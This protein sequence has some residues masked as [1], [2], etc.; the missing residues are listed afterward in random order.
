MST[1]KFDKYNDLISMLF[2]ARQPSDI[3]AYAFDDWE[4][5]YLLVDAPLGLQL[6]LNT[7]AVDTSGTNEYMQWKKVKNILKAFLTQDMSPQFSNVGWYDRIPFMIS[8]LDIRL[9]C[10][11]Q[12]KEAIDQ[13]GEFDSF[14]MSLV[15][16]Y[17][18][19]LANVTAVE[20]HQP[21]P[22]E[23]IQLWN[24]YVSEIINKW[25]TENGK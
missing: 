19:I 21:V 23:T 10:P 11:K 24:N 16:D 25:K 18:L 3:Y 4:V 12:V 7:Q 9:K 22:S 14:R 17:G 2:E 15:V 1:Y 5:T 20:K 6:A 8:K 13:T